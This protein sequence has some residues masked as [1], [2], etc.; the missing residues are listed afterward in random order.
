MIYKNI[1]KNTLMKCENGY[2][3]Y[4]EN[5]MLIKYIGQH[6]NNIPPY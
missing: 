2:L 6:V 4:E 1:A 5:I 3:R